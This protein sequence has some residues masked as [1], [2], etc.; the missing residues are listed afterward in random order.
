MS[1]HALILARGGSKGIPKKNI[2]KL[3]GVPLLVY[4]VKAALVSGEFAKVVVSSDDAEILEIAKKAGAEAFERD[5]ITAIDTASSEAGIEDYV[6]RTPECDFLCLIQC[7]SPL[8]DANDFK[9]GFALFKSK[10]ADSLVTV[11]R[12]HRFLWRVDEDGQAS[13]KNYD[14]VKRP[15]RQDWQGELI[16]NGA[17]YIFKVS[18]FQSSGSRLS[19]KVVALEMSEETL[20]EIDS[21]TDWKIVEYLAAEK[22]QSI[23]KSWGFS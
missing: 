6:R 18:S 9:N 1:T 5:P 23:P 19:G 22:F 13:A 20:V 15:R 12:T 21:L 11:V 7:T 17:F 2:K 10:N 16:E 4:N 14:P 8:T 3:N